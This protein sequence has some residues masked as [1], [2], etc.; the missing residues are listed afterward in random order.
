MKITEEKINRNYVLWVDFLKKY[1][2]FS[3]EL[4]N[5]Y[6]ELIKNGSY[7]LTET[8]GAAYKGSLLDVVISKLCVIATHINKCAF[9]ENDKGKIMHEHLFCDNNS[10]MKVLLLQHIAKSEMFIPST[11]QWKI[12]KGFYYEF[13]P[14]LKTSMKLGERSVFLCMKYGIRLTEEEYDAMKI[15]DNEE[16]DKNNSFI[17][18]LAELVKIANQLTAIETYQKNKTSKIS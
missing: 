11:E 4:V 6:G 17:T 13:N 14:N 12:N 10:L 8:T 15:C 18:P 5:D 3:E 2:C 7:A 9:G 16:K 1:N